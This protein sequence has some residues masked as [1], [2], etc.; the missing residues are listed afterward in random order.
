MPLNRVAGCRP[1]SRRV[2]VFGVPS[3]SSVCPKSSTAPHPVLRISASAAS[4]S[5]VAPQLIVLYAN[6]NPTDDP[7]LSGRLALLPGHGEAFAEPSLR[8][9]VEDENRQDG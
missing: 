6:R 8:H 1:P 4:R 3:Q 5:H 2:S 7:F 9:D